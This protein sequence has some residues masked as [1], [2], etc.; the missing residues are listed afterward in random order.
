MHTGVERRLIFIRISIV[1]INKPF[2]MFSISALRE[3]EFLVDM[4]IHNLKILNFQDLPQSTGWGKVP[5][6]A[7]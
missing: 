1:I 7:F 4:D 5:T 2:D 3:P 6:P